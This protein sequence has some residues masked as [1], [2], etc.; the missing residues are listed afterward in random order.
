MVPIAKAPADAPP[1]DDGD[2]VDPDVGELFTVSVKALPVR[3]NVSSGPTSEQ[4]KI[5]TL[6]AGTPVRILEK[7]STEANGVHAYVSSLPGDAVR[8]T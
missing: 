4:E 5:G 2:A 6:R 7:R 8:I 3:S 1:V